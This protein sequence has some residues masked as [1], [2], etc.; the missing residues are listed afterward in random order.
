MANVAYLLHLTDLARGLSMKQTAHRH[1]KAWE[2]VKKIMYN[3]RREHECSNNVELLVKMM[4]EGRIKM[5]EI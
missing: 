1:G 4:R 5:E 2:T 3:A